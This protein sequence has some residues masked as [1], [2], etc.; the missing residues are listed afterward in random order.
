MR[1]SAIL[2]A[3]ALASTPLHA[4][5]G[6]ARTI[7]VVLSLASESAKFQPSGFHPGVFVGTELPWLTRRGHRLLQGFGLGYW[8]HAALEH[9]LLVRTEL[10]YRYTLDAGL[11]LE[12]LVG[13]GYLHTFPTEEAW[14]ASDGWNRDSSG[15]PHFLGS[16]AGGVGWDFS[17]LARPVP[18]ALFAR[19][20]FDVET[21]GIEG[22][23]VY[24][25]TILQLGLRVPIGAASPR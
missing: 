7:P 14:S 11:S 5:E 3:L 16:V 15:A 23:P 2:L 18:L 10:G 8:D 20:E 12:L 19:Y 25:H 4:D 17:H 1:T 24:P 21:P 6:H 13:A 22:T 9:A